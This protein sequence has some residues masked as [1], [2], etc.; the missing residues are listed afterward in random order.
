MGDSTTYKVALGS[1]GQR[2]SVPVGTNVLRV[3]GEPHRELKAPE[4][5]IIIEN[6]VAFTTLLHECTVMCWMDNSLPLYSMNA[7]C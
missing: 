6:S 5:S 3:S 1:L 4:R 2:N 7:L